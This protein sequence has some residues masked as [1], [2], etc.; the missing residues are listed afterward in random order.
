MSDVDYV[1]SVCQGC[2]S[3]QGFSCAPDMQLFTTCITVPTDVSVEIY[4]HR[5]TFCLWVLVLYT[6]FFICKYKLFLT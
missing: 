1:P 3:V 5:F 4:V 2:V 6:F